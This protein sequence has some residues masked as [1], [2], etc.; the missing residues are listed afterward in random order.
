MDA[1]LTSDMNTQ[2]R[3]CALARAFERTSEHAVRAAA[4]VIRL[5]DEDGSIAARL[6][7]LQVSHCAFETFLSSR[8][9]RAIRA[10]SQMF[11]SK[12]AAGSVSATVSSASLAGTLPRAAARCL[13]PRPRTAAPPATQRASG[14]STKPDVGTPPLRVLISG[15]GVAGLALALALR[16]RGVDALVFERVRAETIAALPSGAFARRCSAAHSSD[17]PRSHWAAPVELRPRGSVPPIACAGRAG[18]GPSSRGR[19]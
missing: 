7:Q 11:L 15:G 4:C 17:S 3:G 8:P 1:P 10:L 9:A 6:L 19:G 2:E 16:E 12:P 18:A 14:A 13:A 5:A